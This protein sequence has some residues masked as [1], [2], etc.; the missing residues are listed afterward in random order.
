MTFFGFGAD[1][2]EALCTVTNCYHR[3]FYFLLENSGISFASSAPKEGITDGSRIASAFEST[4]EDGCVVSPTEKSE[5]QTWRAVADFL[6]L[7]ETHAE[8]VAPEVIETHISLVFLTKHHVY[9]L[10]KPLQ[11]DFLD[12]STRAARKLACEKEVTL[13]RRMAP[14]VYLDVIAITRD[15]HGELAF[16][17]PGQIIESVVK[18][19]R[20]PK[21]LMLDQMIE[22]RLTDAGQLTPSLTETD[23]SSLASK[24]ADFYRTATVLHPDDKVFVGQMAAHVRG[25]RTELLLPQH[26]LNESKVKRIHGRQL[27]FINLESDL[28][29]SR[30]AEDRVV[31]GHGD[32]RPEHVCMEKRPVIFDCIEFNDELRQLDT[33]DELSFLAM[34]CERLGAK[35]IGDE[36]LSGYVKATGDKVPEHL[37]AFYKSYRACVRAKVAVLRGSQ[38]DDA[39]REASRRSARAYLDIADVRFGETSTPVCVM[40]RGAVGTGK[41]TLARSLAESLGMEMLQTDQIRRQMTE[42]INEG[43]DGSYG[44][45]R[46]MIENRKAVYERMLDV[47]SER[48]SER[49]SVILDACFLSLDLQ[50]RVQVLTQAL[51]VPLLVVSCL[52]SDEIAT[53]RII[54]RAKEP[55]CLSEARPE[56]LALQRQ[57][58]EGELQGVSK[59]LIDTTTGDTAA[60]VRQ[61]IDRVRDLVLPSRAPTASTRGMTPPRPS[62][63]APECRA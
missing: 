46:Y 5:N 22:G 23:A 38:L 32:L 55:G 30:I 62:I 63:T 49:I 47:A 6:R 8:E 10:K 40:I 21:A 48:L 18:M 3:T 33:A 56:Y 53:A 20:L 19:R 2:E 42:G 24:L 36:I 7:K 9:K 51:G 27:Q 12:Y 26:G 60:H 54:A 41:S 15:D 28:F 16:E 31:D 11:F 4:R 35:A 34:E 25:N 1:V 50:Q 52:C 61:I 44:G 58:D 17:G 59:L 39:G 57:D 45:G 14:D 13:N 37:L 43:D 29:A